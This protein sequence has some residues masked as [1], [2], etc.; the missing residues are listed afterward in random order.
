MAEFKV[1]IIETLKMSVD[2]EADTKEEAE[3]IARDQ[4]KDGIHI[5]DSEHFS[6]VTFEAGNVWGNK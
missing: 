5:L 4:W 3:I 6:G 1:T 2:I